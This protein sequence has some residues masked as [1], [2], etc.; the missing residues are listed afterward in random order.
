MFPLFISSWFCYDLLSLK[1]M[2]CYEVRQHL[3]SYA[4]VVV[5][6]IDGRNMMKIN[7]A[8]T[9]PVKH[10]IDVFIFIKKFD[11]PLSYCNT[12]PF[13]RGGNVIEA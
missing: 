10:V 1:E 11:R 4:V 12:S 6:T 7:M 3:P 9:E 13:I 8:K 5:I 2:V